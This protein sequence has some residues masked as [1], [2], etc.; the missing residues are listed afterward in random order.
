VY[1]V[2][3]EEE[4]QFLFFSNEL[5]HQGDLH[6]IDAQKV[7]DAT[8]NLT[9]SARDANQAFADTLVGIQDRNMR[10]AQSLYENG[11]G[12]LNS[13]AESTSQL[14]QT[15]VEQSRRQQ[16]AFATLIRSSVDS[17]VKFF[18]TPFSFYQGAL[19]TAERRLENAQQ[20]T[21]H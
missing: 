19:K 7:N 3:A 5:G 17:Y 2:V 14:M 12:I 11:M 16:E 13:N 8:W 6:M 18:I 10:F 21:D 9:S 20:A 4:Y 15:L 1:L